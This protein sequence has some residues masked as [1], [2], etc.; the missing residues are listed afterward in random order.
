MRRFGR[1]ALQPR[2][3]MAKLLAIEQEVCHANLENFW[4]AQGMGS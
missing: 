3:V 4:V 1:H 2:A